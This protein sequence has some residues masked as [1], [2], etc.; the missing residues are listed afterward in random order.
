MA[1]LTCA[2][3]GITFKCDHFPMQ[4]NNREAAHPVFLLPQHKLLSYAGKWSA[5]ELTT[6]DSYLLFLAL[7]NSTTLIEWRTHA[8]YRNALTDTIVANNMEAMLRI[9]GKINIIHHPKFVLPSF[10]ITRDTCTLENAQHWIEA[11]HSV[12]MEFMRGY[13]EQT[14]QERIKRREYAL[15]RMIK[16]TQL[17][18]A[19]KYA[20]VLAE[21]SELAG[22][23]PN[24]VMMHPL[25]KNPTTINEYW[26]EII[27]ACIRE[28]KIFQYPTAD[29]DEL[30]LHCEENIPHGSISAA[31]LMD[32]LRAGKKSQSSYLCLNDFDI[33]A[34]K[35]GT[36]KSEDVV[37]TTNKIALIQSA[38]AFEPKRTDYSSEIEFVRAK[39]KWKMKLKYGDITEAVHMTVVETG[40]GAGAGS[41]ECI[42][43]C[44]DI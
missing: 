18:N 41:S 36:L 14:E 22:H 31:S 29:V 2:Y 26:K 32:L 17:T 24:F 13:K 19:T 25:N 8:V 27:I 10:V 12:F 34:Y 20:K 28:E 23:F 42:K 1:T 33:L 7:M 9:I 16:S 37:E 43:K 39:M 11:W 44:E 3:S 15:E 40:T 30:I 4:L 35:S 5:G 21:W 6:T 38:P